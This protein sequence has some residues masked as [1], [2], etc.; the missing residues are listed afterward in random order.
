MAKNY[1]KGS[2]VSY[3]SDITTYYYSNYVIHFV[4]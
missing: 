1:F 2:S 4:I 3:P